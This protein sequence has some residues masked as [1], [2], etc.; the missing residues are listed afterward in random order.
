MPIS[1]SSD[2]T[3]AV[4]VERILASGL[5]VQLPWGKPGIIRERELAWHEHERQN[6]RQRFPVGT[7]LHAVVLDDQ[8]DPVELSLRLAQSDPWRDIESRYRVGQLVDGVVSGHG[9]RVTYIE[10]AGGIVGRLPDQELPAWLTGP[11]DEHLWVGDPVR[12]IVRSIHPADR[13]FT[14]SMRS[15]LEHRWCTAFESNSDAPQIDPIQLDSHN[16]ATPDGARDETVS[17]APKRSHIIVL[18]EDDPAQNEAIVRWLRNAG[19]QV[20]GAETADEGLAIVRVQRPEVLICDVGLADGDG[21]AAVALALAG[22]PDLRCILMTDWAT[23]DSRRDE[24]AALEQRGVA[25]MIKPILPSELA[26]VLDWLDDRDLSSAQVAEAET[27]QPGLADAMPST[28]E[29]IAPGLSLSATRHALQTVLRNLRRSTRA[30]KVVLFALHPQLRQ[31]QVV[32]HVGRGPINDDAVGNLIY[33]PVRNVAEEGV[34]VHVEDADAMAGYV[35]YLRPL[36]EFRS[37]VGAPVPC[38]LEKRYA[39]FL[40]HPRVGFTGK[41]I[42]E[43]ATAAAMAAGAILERQAFINQAGEIQRMVLMGQLSR[44]LIHETNHQLNPVLFSLSDLKHQ[45]ALLAQAQRMGASRGVDQL[46]SIYQTVEQLAAGVEKLVK[47]TRL[48]GRVTVQDQE[49]HVRIDLVV[50]QCL[51]IVRDVANQARVRLHLHPPPHV[52]VTRAKASQVQQVLLNLLLNAIQ[53]IALLRPKQGGNVH[54]RQALRAKSE[55]EHV[56]TVYIEDDGPGIHRQ[57]W[58]RIYDLG[59]SLRKGEGSGLGLYVARSLIENTGGALKVA[60]SHA[61]WGTTML[62]EFPVRLAS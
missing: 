37:C 59:F 50:E 24:I 12:V 19:Q 10:L 8:R 61:L 60:E 46:A 39:L 58:Q 4:H 35:R 40:F 16:D 6:W 57:L 2:P 29:Q 53:Q 28:T 15:L 9:A 52:L 25:L 34:A 56:I 55:D 44:S 32:A 54:I 51:E 30:G 45:L 36:L 26:Y 33:S 17:H 21:I 18:V 48:F 13:M 14:V 49:E 20:T 23:A 31:V 43:A 3:V 47:T 27:S 5:L 1:P 7:S 41:S 38:Q 62:A 22:A 42:E 11:P